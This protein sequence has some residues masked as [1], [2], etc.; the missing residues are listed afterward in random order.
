M[1]NANVAARGRHGRA[2]RANVAKFVMLMRWRERRLAPAQLQQVVVRRH[3]VARHGEH[4]LPFAF[5]REKISGI[6]RGSSSES[7]SE[8][9]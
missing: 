7:A 3:V 5:L 1:S 6:S 2:S 8:N 4:Q 9:V